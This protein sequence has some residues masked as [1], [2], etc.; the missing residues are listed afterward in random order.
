MQKQ[1]WKGKCQ[2]IIKV[3]VIFLPQPT[4]FW[5]YRLVPQLAVALFWARILLTCPERT[6]AFHPH[7]SASQGPWIRALCHNAW[8]TKFLFKCTPQKCPKGPTVLTFGEV[9]RNIGSHDQKCQCPNS[10]VLGYMLKNSEWLWVCQWAAGSTVVECWN[11]LQSHQRESV[12]KLKSLCW[13][14]SLL[15]ACGTWRPTCDGKGEDCSSSE[16]RLPSSSCFLFHLS[17]KSIG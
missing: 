11:S 9:I 7:A 16:W 4:Q 2:H 6:W 15:E 5:H 13:K 12:W 14:L 3:A 1:H 17:Y 10:S 8:P